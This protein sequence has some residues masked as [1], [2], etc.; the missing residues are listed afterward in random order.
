MYTNIHLYI[1][2][3]TYFNNNVKTIVLELLITTCLQKIYVS[4]HAVTIKK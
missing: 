4:K 3:F 2:I 1:Y